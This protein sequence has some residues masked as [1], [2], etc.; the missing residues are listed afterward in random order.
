MPAAYNA[1]LTVRDC[2]QRN[3]LN[4]RA[5]VPARMRVWITE[6]GVFPAGPLDRTWLQAVHLGVM[7]ANLVLLPQVDIILPY[8]LVC[9]DST[10]PAITTST[11]PVVDPSEKNNTWYNTPKGLMQRE[12]FSSMRNAS[13]IQPLQFAPMSSNGNKAHIYGVQTL[14]KDGITR[15]LF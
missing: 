6:L 15:D 4:L 5:T 11:G 8:C 7:L 1:F 9:A 14:G 10:G 2:V 12:I 13:S 3:A